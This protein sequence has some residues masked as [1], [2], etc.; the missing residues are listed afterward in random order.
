MAA[1]EDEGSRVHGFKEATGVSARV[2]PPRLQQ[3]QE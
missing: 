2:H 1:A 3:E